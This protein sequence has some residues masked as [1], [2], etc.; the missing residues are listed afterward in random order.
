MKHWPFLAVPLFFAATVNANADEGRPFRVLPQNEAAHSF[1]QNTL[2]F[3]GNDALIREPG[4]S[5]RD[6]NNLYSVNIQKVD[7]KKLDLSAFGEVLHQVPGQYAVMRIESDRVEELSH[8]LHDQGLAC[9]LVFRLFGDTVENS[10]LAAVPSPVLE[11]VQK[12]PAVEAMTQKVNQDNIHQTI[13]EMSSIY[14]RH[15]SSDTGVP[16]AQQLVEKYQVLANG[17]SDVQIGT[18]DHGNIT[19]Q[20]SLMVRIEGTTKPDEII[21]LGSHIDSVSYMGGRSP[22]ADDNASGTATNMEIFRVLMESDARFE[23]TIE[24]HGYAAEEA[25]LLGSQDIAKKYKDAGKNV[26][27]MVQH[28]MVLYRKDSEDMIWFVTNSTNKDLNK[29]L[30]QLADSY[31]GVK[32]DQASLLGGTSDHA[33]WNRQGFAAAFPFEKPSAYN[34]KIHTENDTIENSGAFSQAA[35]FAR[36]GVAFA[37]HYAGLK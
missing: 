20:N 33:S 16:V 26:I 25:G 12:L 31:A 7:L 30:Q 27:A 24:I 4:T 17:R 28:D 15:H 10:L 14:S 32:W 13:E 23:R 21:I 8:A 11:T 37:D 6:F 18:F 19:K 22:G 35:A 9:G 3:V 34:K 1:S 29:G 36:L 5:A 2:M